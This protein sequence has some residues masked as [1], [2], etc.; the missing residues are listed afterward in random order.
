MFKF[1][2]SFFGSLSKMVIAPKWLAVLI[3]GM[4]GQN[5]ETP[6][7]MIRSGMNSIN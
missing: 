3:K 5:V 7:E 2:P 1:V 6:P 4:K